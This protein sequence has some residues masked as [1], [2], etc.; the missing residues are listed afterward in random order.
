MRPSGAAASLR[1]LRAAPLIVPDRFALW[2]LLPEDDES[3]DGELLQ[4]LPSTP[5]ARLL[6]PASGPSA[7]AP[8]FASGASVW[9]TNELC[10]DDGFFALSVLPRARGAE[11]PRAE[12]RA[13]GEGAPAAAIATRLL[14]ANALVNVWDFYVEPKHAC[15]LHEHLLPYVFI[16][17]SSGVTRNLD[18]QLRETGESAFAAGHARFVDVDP[19]VER[20]I[21]AFR[22]AGTQPLEQYV[23]EF[24]A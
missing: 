17:R 10:V 18:A 15:E 21:H 5:L 8:V 9:R 24:K 13:R 2:A 19:S 4:T 20:C 16:N 23:V 14:L 1:R 11:S 6:L 22:N 12:S 7:A 3:C